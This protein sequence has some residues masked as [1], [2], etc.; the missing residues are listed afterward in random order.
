M[1]LKKFNWEIWQ[2]IAEHLTHWTNIDSW[3]LVDCAIRC[4]DPFFVLSKFPIVFA[5]S[6][7]SSWK[8][9]KKNRSQIVH[10][11]K[12][13][14]TKTIWTMSFFQFVFLFQSAHS[15]MQYHSNM[16]YWT[17]SMAILK[18]LLKCE[19]I[20]LAGLVCLLF[21]F[22]YRFTWV[23]S[24]TRSSLFGLRHSRN[25]YTSSYFRSK[26]QTYCTM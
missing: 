11:V 12:S 17:K 14:I 26:L 21:Y 25:C 2:F 16:H 6:S 23:C 20:H 10:I 24:R 8:N 9:T 4:I 5:L 7:N 3:S 15:R 19:R 13:R 22:V 1:K 18:Y